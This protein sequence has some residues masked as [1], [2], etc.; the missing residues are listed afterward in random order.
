MQ[1]LTR[2]KVIAGLGMTVLGLAVPFSATWADEAW[3]TRSVNFIVPFPAG[4]PVDTSAR[5][6]TKPLGEKWGQSAV[7][8][9]RAGAG[10]I[11]GARA[12]LKEKPDG[13]SFFFPAIHHAV[14]PS[15]R[16]D[17]GYDIQNDYELVGTVARFPI[18]LVVHPSLPVTNVVELI[19]YAKANDISFSSSGT[20]GGTH[21]AGELFNSMAGVKIQHVPYRGSAP[22]MQDLVGGQVQVM[23]ADAPSA[24]PFI[25]SGHIRAL[26]VGNP[27][28]SS[29]APDV[30][31]IAE[32][33]VPG[34]E[35]YSWTALVAPKGTPAD[36]VK[37]VNADLSE[38]LNDPQIGPAMAAAGAEPMPGSPEDFARFLDNEIKKW[39]T[40]IRE[41]NI[42]IEQ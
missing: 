15:L 41:A 19:E 12:A 9:N 35:A 30:P 6:V 31:P 34:Y 4:G 1:K 25:K 42:T 7:V 11:V 27:E 18:I 36:I 24:L 13:Y 2:R 10:G 39:G 14:L 8:D 17:L 5:F 16:Q 21:L 22:A 38:I 37:K 29:L 28:P 20:G 33:G 23:F 40:V 3:P 32:A 26:G